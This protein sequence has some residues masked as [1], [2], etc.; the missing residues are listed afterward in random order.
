MGEG[1]LT[2]RPGTLETLKV[3]TKVVQN[4]SV[5]TFLAVHESFFPHCDHLLLL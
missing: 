1:V 5:N 4:N 2:K 3:I